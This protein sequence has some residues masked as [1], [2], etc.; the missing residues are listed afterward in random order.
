MPTD[1]E[2]T[3]EKPKSKKPAKK[4]QKRLPKE[5]VKEE[6]ENVPQEPDRAQAVTKKSQ[7]LS[8][9]IATI[10]GE[11]VTKK[12][13]TRS[14]KRRRT[15]T[16]SKANKQVRDEETEESQSAVVASSDGHEPESEWLSKITLHME[17]GR[18]SIWNRMRTKVRIQSNDHP[19]RP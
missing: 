16:I 12:G 4:K 8:E 6:E 13:D 3:K 15:I 18:S 10:K 5:Q 11:H 9:L 17:M 2:D 19:S 1:Q 14:E 7:R